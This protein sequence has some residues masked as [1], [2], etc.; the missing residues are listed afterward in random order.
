MSKVK[1]SEAFTRERER[2]IEQVSS[3]FSLMVPPVDLMI[4]VCSY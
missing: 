1:Q 3:F 4:Y 2:E